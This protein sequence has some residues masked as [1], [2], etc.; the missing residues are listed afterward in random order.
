M[1]KGGWNKI[2]IMNL[3]YLIKYRFENYIINKYIY[4]MGLWKACGN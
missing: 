4:M 2:I 1:S 3:S